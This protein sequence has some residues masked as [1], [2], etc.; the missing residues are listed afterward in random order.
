MSSNVKIIAVFVAVLLFA[1]FAYFL[2]DT[3][4]PLTREEKLAEIIHLE[5]QRLL[6][7][8]L[9]AY[10]EADSSEIRARAALA[11]A[12]IGGG[13]SGDH[14]MKLVRED[15]SIDVAATSA[16]G[17]GLIGQPKYAMPLLE[18]AMDLPSAVAAKAVEA[19]G[20]LVDSL[21]P[22]VARELA[23]FLNHP[24]PDVREAACYGLFHCRG[25]SQAGVV[26]ALLLTEE[27]HLVR[28]AALYMLAR[29]GIKDAEGVYVEFLADSDPFARSLA[30]RGLSHVEGEDAQHYIAIAMNDD[31]RQV[32]AQAIA[33]LAGKA[34]ES[35]ARK[36]AERLARESNEKLIIALI[37]ALRQCESP[38]GVDDVL[39]LLEERPTDDIVP[40]A[41]KYLAVIQGDHSVN[42]ID[43]VLNNK[44]IARV[45]AACAEAYGLTENRNVVQRLAVL[46]GDTDPQVRAAA[47]SVL[48]VVDSAN[49]KF[50]IDK[51]LNDSDFVMVALAVDQ[52]G[53]RQLSSYLPVLRTMMSRGNEIEV[54]IRRSILGAIAP[55]LKAGSPD[56]VVM[57]ILVAGILDPSYAVRR[58][59]AELYQKDLGQDQ[60]SAVYPVDTRIKRG[61]IERAI[62]KYRVNP[63]AMVTT[64]KGKFEF[65]LYFDVA[66]LTVINFIFLVNSDFYQNLIFHRVVPNFVVQGG[67]PRGDGW[68]G[69]SYLIRDEYSDEPYL[70][71]TVGIA[72]SGKDT[73]GSQ[74]FIALSPQPRLEARYTVFGQVTEGMDV[75]D[76]LLVGDV[77]EKIE[78][79]EGQQ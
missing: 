72:T 29:L 17:L 20:R 10:L 59:A 64:S 9:L 61:A 11:V 8:K 36:L 50:Y 26:E 15:P 47:F 49:A 51:A 32:V 74:F 71:G 25:R 55:Y 56:T 18:L 77:I 14:L 21:R 67:D 37:N 46:F 31:N 27:D 7:D 66:P 35:A 48:S 19:A 44:P 16:F 24:S 1:T 52:I 30:I 42:L 79:K 3:L 33:G 6:N 34:T 63:R 5:D 73:G 54:D 23:G 75:V 38:L 69:P 53:Q 41:L 45:R 39:A 40:A 28:V 2:Y 60:W 68:G 62:K 78:I 65:E 43:S 12:R 57:K 58:D 13:G 22:D 4:R 70:R 76:R